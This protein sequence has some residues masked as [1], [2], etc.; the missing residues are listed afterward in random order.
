ML[1]SEN[2][3]LAVAIVA[4]AYT[5]HRAGFRTPRILGLPA[6]ATRLAVVAFGWTLIVGIA[7]RSVG[8][9]FGDGRI[10]V[11][12]SGQMYAYRSREPSRFWGEIA[13]E[14]LLVGGVG[15]FLIV[16]CRKSAPAAR[17]A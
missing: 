11:A 16:V 7:V 9:L 12:Q 10:Q 15:A 8:G 5:W 2:L 4:A 13:G 17:D 14:V 6:R 1:Q 3:L